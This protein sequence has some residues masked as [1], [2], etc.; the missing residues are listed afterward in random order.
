MR[1]RC[2][3]STSSSTTPCAGYSSQ[4]YLV[5]SVMSRE[6]GLILIMECRLSW[7]CATTLGCKNHF[8]I[9]H[10]FELLKQKLQTWEDNVL[11]LLFHYLT[12]ARITPEDMKPQY[13]GAKWIEATLKAASIHFVDVWLHLWSE[14][15]PGKRCGATILGIALGAPL[16]I[17]H[18][19]SATP[20]AASVMVCQDR[21]SFGKKT[22][23][24]EAQIYQRYLSCTSCF[25][26]LALIHPHSRSH[27]NGE[28]FFQFLGWNTGFQFLGLSGDREDFLLSMHVCLVPVF[29]ASDSCLPLE[30]GKPHLWR[31]VIRCET[32][33]RVAS[34]RVKSYHSTAPAV[35]W[36]LFACTWVYSSCMFMCHFCRWAQ[37]LALFPLPSVVFVESRFAGARMFCSCGRWST[38][39]DS[40]E[41]VTYLDTKTCVQMMCL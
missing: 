13:T 28:P 3:K 10:V 21:K 33:R 40:F 18:C 5:M 11:H 39:I 26:Q 16:E 4:T 29:D 24:L 23:V 22:R 6:A 2:A 30:R 31:K 19:N 17:H 32:W 37:Y 41:D 8:C 12:F 20:S 15:D 9:R 36:C 25:T 7:V 38:A 34:P 1:W 27:A 35:F 14:G